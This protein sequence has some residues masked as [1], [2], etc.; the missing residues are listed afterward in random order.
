M[1]KKIF[2]YGIYL[3]V[4]FFALTGISITYV[5]YHQDEIKA[6]ALEKINESINASLSISDSEASL[7]SSFPSV[8]IDLKDPLLVSVAD[9]LL[10]CKELK[11][12]LNLFDFI[13]E[14]YR[15]NELELSDGQIDLKTL[16]N[17]EI[18][19]EIWK[20]DTSTTDKK[21]KFEIE[22]VLL[23]EV[24]I[25][26]VDESSSNSYHSDVENMHA[27]VHLE[28][29]TWDVEIDAA[30]QKFTFIEDNKHRIEEINLDLTCGLAYHQL[31][32]NLEF[33]SIGIEHNNSEIHGKGNLSIDE[34]IL[35]LSVNTQSTANNL[36]DIFRYYY[37]LPDNYKCEGKISIESLLEYSYGKNSNLKL[38][39]NIQLSKA[40]FIET[41]SGEY[42]EKVNYKG[43]FNITDDHSNLIVSEMTSQMA[44]GDFQ[45]NGKVSQIPDP[46]VNLNF[47]GTLNLEELSNFFQFD[48]I[49]FDGK[50][51]FNNTLQGSYLAKDFEDSDWLNKTKIGGS[52][53]LKKG[54]IQWLE[55]NLN[56]NGLTG[57]ME[58]SDK[59]IAVKDLKGDAAS[60][61]FTLNG[62]ISNFL[63]YAFK[64][65]EPLS[66]EAYLESDIIN[67]EEFL[68]A[69]N[70]Q[71]SAALSFPDQIEFKLNSDIEEIS[72]HKFKANNVRGLI[73]YSKHQFEANDVSFNTC[74]GSLQSK[75]KINQKNDNRFLVSSETK[76]QNLNIKEVFEQF[77]NFDQKF[78]TAEHLSGK[79]T[80][81][82]FFK[83]EMDQF[84]DFRK[85]TIQ[86]IADIKL[87]NGELI[88]HPAMMEIAEYLRKK[89][90]LVPFLKIDEFQSNV[91]HL[92]FNTIQ[93]RIEIKDSKIV[94]PKMEIQ[95]N[96]MDCNISGLH[97]FDNKVDYRLDF[98]MREMLKQ[99][100]EEIEEIVV[101]D[102]GTGSR[103]FIAMQGSVDNLE[104]SFDKESARQ[105]RKDDLKKAKEGFLDIFRKKDD[106][107]A[108]PKEKIEIEIK[109]KEIAS[110]GKKKKGIG[111]LFK[112]DSDLEE[113][114][115]LEI[116]IIE[117]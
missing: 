22:D 98:R 80:A 60:S 38:E 101:E 115:A 12:K 62:T 17:G 66:I 13:S 102:D 4:L 49:L 54:Q 94:I 37:Q 76:A 75:I 114:E 70:S 5:Y 63:N 73:S 3:T 42:I 51:T 100:E 79:T 52:A 56:V 40:K 25:T 95:S 86:S 93:N 15:I 71:S 107:E 81:D 68:T 6:L 65:N 103:I 116:E 11:L 1:L 108:Q 106:E 44:H 105:K 23:N 36:L 35:S 28:N 99:H 78:L 74:D 84:L 89:R 31:N 41:V 77:A 47:Q 104:V 97:K 117:D 14:D 61:N 50:I 27:A 72:F 110:K 43:E 55:K 21:L 2:K 32:E 85:N 16:E 39:N 92:S 19:F 67:L 46:N 9:T 69:D 58:F 112:K 34:R 26:Y 109:D 24:L 64:E 10:S 18:N 82:I 7:L 33:N 48:S 8:S 59:H 20:N 57:E 111:S 45:V 113:E 29:D 88:K 90:L 91:E 96:A 83:G 87:E 30:I 53:S